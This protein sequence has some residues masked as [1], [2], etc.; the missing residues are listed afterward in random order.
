VDFVEDVM[1]L[2][3]LVFISWLWRPGKVIGEKNLD[4]HSE[5]GT[6]K[7]T[8]MPLTR[9]PNYCT[10]AVRAAPAEKAAAESDLPRQ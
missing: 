4:R 9:P 2:A 10:L 7:R 1:R 5:R 8:S 6:L 3:G